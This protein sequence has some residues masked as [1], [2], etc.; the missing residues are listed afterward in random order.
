MQWN[1]RYL[2]WK[3]LPSL[4]LPQPPCTGGTQSRK[5]QGLS[6]DETAR[7]RGGER[8]PSIGET[9]NVSARREMRANENNI[10][11]YDD[12]FCHRCQENSHRMRACGR[13]MLLAAA[14]HSR[15]SLAGVGSGTGWTGACDRG[16]PAPA[17]CTWSKLLLGEVEN[18]PGNKRKVNAYSLRVSPTGQLN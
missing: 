2:T 15:S 14:T 1:P 11:L 9:G 16:T 7:S 4:L 8:N 6:Q 3:R 5:G 18:P 17:R 13:A 12:I 10:C